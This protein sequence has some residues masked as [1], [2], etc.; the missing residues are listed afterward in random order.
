MVSLAL[1][2]LRRIVNDPVGLSQ[3]LFFL[4]GAAFYQKVEDEIRDRSGVAALRKIAQE[5]LQ[6][7][8][9]LLGIEKSHRRPVCFSI[10]QGFGLSGRLGLAENRMGCRRRKGE[11]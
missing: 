3:D 1:A 7:I 9:P 8:D 4:R 5:L 11:D 10:G 2:V 6:R